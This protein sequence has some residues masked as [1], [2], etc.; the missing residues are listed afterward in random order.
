MTV[1][2]ERR[3]MY[4]GNILGVTASVDTNIPFNTVIQSNNKV[5]YDSTNKSILIKNTGYY[6][7][8]IHLVITGVAVGDITVSLLANG[9][10]LTEAQAIETSSAT[11]DSITINI[12]DVFKVNPYT[13][14]EYANLSVQLSGA[15]MITSGVVTV[16]E[17]Q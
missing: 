10:A 2:F 14:N 5:S 17:I 16:K 12:H 8:D 6:E 9:T 1:F 4:K 11:T 15:C 7:A 3:V 13:V